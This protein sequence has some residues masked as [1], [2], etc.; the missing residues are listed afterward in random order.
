MTL[1]E[2]TVKLFNPLV[3]DVMTRTKLGMSLFER[4]SRQYIA[5]NNLEQA[6][7]KIKDYWQQGRYSTFDILGEASETESAAE[8]YVSAYLLMSEMLDSNISGSPG[9]VTI[10]VKPTCICVVNK[11]HTEL[12]DQGSLKLTLELMVEKSKVPITLDMEDHNWT[13]ISLDA[14]HHLWNHSYENFGIVLQSRLN[15]TESDIQNLIK[16]D[17]RVPKESIRV[18]ACIG[19]YLE[20]KDIATNDKDE[21]KKRLI[22][23]VEKMFN[24]GIYIEIATHDLLVVN[25]IQDIIKRKNIP[26]DRF[27][28][29]FL[30]GVQNA[31]NIERE[32]MDKGYKVRYYMPAEIKTGDGL[33]YM[34]RRLKANPDMLTL[35]AVNFAQMAFERINPRRYHAKTSS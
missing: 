21:A 15:R 1:A 10:S 8:G 17:Y 2:K 28:F 20:P 18:R 22:I 34:I 35:G 29:Q 9:S 26:A 4:L 32:L 31:Y 19:I 30:K 27:E 13:D 7:A 11:D 33:P 23:N 14:A 5:G 3:I 12:L 24:A 6:L 16:S 25:R